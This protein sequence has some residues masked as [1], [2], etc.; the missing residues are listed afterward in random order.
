M[1]IAGNALTDFA[2][3]MRSPPFDGRRWPR[4]ATIRL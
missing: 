2:M 1:E 4:P 3:L